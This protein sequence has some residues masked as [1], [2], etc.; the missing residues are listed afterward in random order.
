M[1]K[2][3]LDDCFPHWCIPQDSFTNIKA[4]ESFVCSICLGIYFSPVIDEC[5]HIFGEGC[6]KKYV[7]EKKTCPITNK[8]YSNNNTFIPVFALKDFIQSMEMKCINS[9][10][11]WK[12]CINALEKHLKNDCMFETV[13]C[14]NKACKEKVERRYMEEH[15]NN[16]CKFEKQLCLFSKA[17][18]CFDKVPER[19]MVEHLFK[20]HQETLGNAAQI[21]S[22][23]VSLNER[24][25]FDMDLDLPT[26]PRNFCYYKEELNKNFSSREESVNHWQSK[27]LIS[28]GDAPTCY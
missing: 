6:V 20:K 27:N 22:G 4:T 11:E 9:G 12:N 28:W 2:K 7:N 8:N 10:C 24:K 15:L 14:L 5:G 16:D 1:K 19:L 3:L 13:D 25:D 18:N 17:V 26:N 23:S 21:Y